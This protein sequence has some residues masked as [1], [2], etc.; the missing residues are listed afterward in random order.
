[1]VQVT[2]SGIVPAS[3]PAAGWQVRYRIKGSGSGYLTPVG[4][5]FMAQPIVFTTTDPPGTLY[6]GHITSDCGGGVLGAQFFWTAPCQCSA[7]YTPAPDGIQCSKTDTIP[8]TITS[9]N[10]CLAP[11]TNG[12]Y[13]AYSSRIY[14]P[15]FNLGTMLLA[16]GTSNPSILGEI[17]TVGQW[18]NPSAL[19]TVG[20]MNRE[21][22][23][24]DA[25][26]DGVRDALAGGVQVTLGFNYNNIGPSRQ[27]YVGISGDN[28][29]ELKVNGISMA[30]FNTGHVNAFKIFHL[31]PV[32]LITGMNSFNAVG[33]GDGSV[34]DSIAMVIYDN[35]AAQ[36][37]AA[38]ADAQLNILFKTSSVRGSHMDVATCPANYNLDTSGGVGAYV[39]TR[40]Q[41]KICNSSDT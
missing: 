17:V 6:E 37:Q 8:A 1:M 5:P 13:S 22:V 7:T 15:G 9:S 24:I 20:P 34:S 16:P 10:Y 27:I 21:G 14:I 23:W 25:N 36:L 32:T 38:T 2:L 39:C 41:Y 31:I 11:S 35:T 29:F 4:N 40:T 19:A 28:W 3:V 12:A 26:C 18:A 33:T 30:L